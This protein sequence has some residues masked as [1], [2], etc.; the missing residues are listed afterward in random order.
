H[1]DE[2]VLAKKEKTEGAAR[3]SGGIL[4]MRRECGAGSTGVAPVRSAI[5]ASVRPRDCRKK[6]GSLI[7]LE[8]GPWC[9]RRPRSEPGAAA[10]TEYLCAVT[11]FAAAGHR[12]RTVF[13]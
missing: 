11:H 9:P 1:R 6:S 7:L 13:G 10:E 4:R 12:R 5:S 2:F 8:F 3:S